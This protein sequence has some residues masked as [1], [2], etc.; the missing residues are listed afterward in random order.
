MAPGHQGPAEQSTMSGQHRRQ[1]SAAGPSRQQS[2]GAGGRQRSVS[3]AAAALEGLIPPSP[4]RVSVT[5]QDAQLTSQLQVTQSIAV[6]GSIRLHHVSSCRNVLICREAASQSR[7]RSRQCIDIDST[8]LW[9]S[10]VGPIAFNLR[11]MPNVYKSFMQGIVPLL[12][13]PRDGGP[14]WLANVANAF[15]GESFPETPPPLASGVLPEVTIQQFQRCY[16][17]RSLC[18]PVPGGSP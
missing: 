13:N 15:G 11:W 5:P 6:R 14:N 16:L 12:N 2:L 3:L 18:S 8:M 9:A 1:S 17:Q 10:G 7:I 4:R